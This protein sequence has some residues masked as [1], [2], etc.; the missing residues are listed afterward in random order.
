MSASARIQL[1]R[2]TARAWQEE[3][4]VLLR[5]EP[6]IEVDTGRMKI[7]NGIGSWDQ[8]VYVG[9][10]GEG[11]GPQ[12]PKGD[13]GDTG[14]PGPMGPQGEIGPI[15]LKGDKGD[16][17]DPGD[18]GAP[19]ATGATG[20]TG[21]T[22]ATGATGEQGPQGIQ[23]VP[24]AT[25]PTG[26]T[27]AKGDTGASGAGG[28]AYLSGSGA[29]SSSLGIL[30][31]LYED[32]LTGDLYQKQSIAGQASYRSVATATDTNQQTHNVP[33]PSDAAVG[34]LLVMALASY[35]P[36]S[37]IVV[38]TP[39]GWT[40]RGAQ[41]IGGSYST[42]VF[43]RTKDGSE[44]ST[45][46]VAT[47]NTSSRS[48]LSIIAYQNANGVDV[49]ATATGS[50]NTQTLPSVT[51]TA[52]NELLVGLTLIGGDT[53]GVTPDA[54]W[55]E[56]V[57]YTIDS[58]GGTLHVMDRTQPTAG[59][60]GTAVIFWPT[61]ADIAYGYTIAVKGGGAT[62][63]TWVRMDKRLLRSLVDAKGDLLV[64]SAD[65][66][67]ARLPVGSNN[68][69]LTADSAQS[70]GM[71]WAAAGGGLVLLNT[72]NLGANGTFD[73]SSIPQTYNDLL[74]MLIA[75]GV[76]TGGSEQPI[77]R[78]NN[79]TAANYRRASFQVWNANPG[80][81]H[82]EAD[83]SILSGVLPDSNGSYPAGAFGIVEIV[84]PGYASTVWRKSLLFRSY[85]AYAATPPN[86]DFYNNGGGVW[87]SQAA[88]NRIQI[89]G[90]VGNLVTGSQL[91]IYG[92]N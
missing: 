27:G 22:G 77:V 12:G 11:S 19:G 55:V 51:T 43:T 92:R 60:S 82:G 62:V 76:G 18:D 23:G 1:R 91:R 52:I 84:I 36:G 8:L 28:A 14:D 9:G 7:G 47:N 2:R 24:G 88:I 4:P 58:V 80:Y 69:V 73:V 59:A 6:G 54:A 38:T 71:K 63:P 20:L 74:L 42:H 13:K 65:D 86:Y 53:G 10:E 68:Q 35:K 90:S 30:Q 50:N 78:F 15:G 48:L 21:A 85:A 83:T 66:S 3:N 67:V 72:V 16:K 5:G 49:S 61:V 45:V 81:P 17:G 39:S 34:D 32:I 87:G 44:S 37:Q 46:T 57:E 64:G 70:S 56:R 75:K 31:D 79:D 41:Y 26:A 25:G 40:S 29:P 89:A 33:I